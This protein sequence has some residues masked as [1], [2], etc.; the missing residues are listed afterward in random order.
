MGIMRD[1]VIPGPMRHTEVMQSNT[2]NNVTYYI[3]VCNAF[4]ACMHDVDIRS[5]LICVFLA[6]ALTW[7]GA[8][9]ETREGGV[10]E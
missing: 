6:D 3:I 10:M 2:Q 9:P 5:T 1:H 8:D 7:A 4:T